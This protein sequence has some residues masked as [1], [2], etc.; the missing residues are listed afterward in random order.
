MGAIGGLI[1][2]VTDGVLAAGLSGLRR[3]GGVLVLGDHVG[4]AIEQRFRGLALSLRVEPGVGPDH[5]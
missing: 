2:V 3:A 5:R 1:R 4:A